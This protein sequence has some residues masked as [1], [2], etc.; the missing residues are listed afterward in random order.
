MAASGSGG[1]RYHIRMWNRRPKR[2]IVIACLA[3]AAFSFAEGVAQGADKD[4][5]KAEAELQGVRQ[6]INQIREQV[7]RDALR[8]DRVAEQLLDAEKTVGGVRAAIDKLQAERASRGR[9]RAELAEQRL[10]QE[11][12]LAAERQS[13]AAQ[14]RAASMMG[15][16]EP[17]KLLLNQSDPALVSRIFTYYSYFGRARAS[18]IAAI[19]TQVA[20][21]DET[22]AQ[23]A[24]EDARLA[25]LEAEQRAELV[26]LKSARD[27][28]GRV[29]ASIKSETRARERQ[30]ARLQTQ[31]AGL[32]KLLREL[33]RAMQR[34]E[35][36]PTDSKT[37]FARLQGKLPWPASGR[38]VA[39]FG[40]TRAGG[41][42][43]DGML[44]G[45]RLARRARALPWPGGICRL[46][47]RPWAADDHRPR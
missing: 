7:T 41:L 31:Q 33:R 22:D 24:A 5:T 46:V 36:F 37:A 30:L 3:F 19:E 38:V 35:K 2:T 26:R 13:L 16:E 12:A 28:R 39:R 47:A 29:L 20:A 4:A 21:L 6:Q 8:R 34:M 1:A 14:I 18:Q 17:F 45:E 15:R 27:E 32:E 40:E 44:L 42:K 11:R 23:L 10:A 43:W 25:A 9:K